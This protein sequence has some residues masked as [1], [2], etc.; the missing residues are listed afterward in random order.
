MAMMIVCEMVARQARTNCEYY[1]WYSRINTLNSFA[2]CASFE[3]C[4]LLRCC[5]H[6]IN[7]L[8]INGHRD[9]LSR[10]IAFQAR[11]PVDHRRS[12]WHV[13]QAAERHAIQMKWR[14]VRFNTVF[15]V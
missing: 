7:M 2:L 4:E 1:I 10:S 14:G 5:V 8:I 9:G 11:A 3:L 13:R 15:K 12:V 6:N